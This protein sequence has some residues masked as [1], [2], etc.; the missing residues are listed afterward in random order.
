MTKVVTMIPVR[1]ASTRLPNKPLLDINGKTLVQR[2]YENVKKVVP[3]DVYIAAGDEVIVKEC[4]KFGAKAILTD[5]SLPSGTD[6][7]AA[8]LKEIDPTGTKYDIV[9][10]FQGDSL[11]VDP[12]INNKLIEI[13]EKT[14]CDIATCGMVFKSKEDSENPANVKIVM[15]LRDGEVE[16]RALYFTRAVAPFTRNPEKVKNQDLYHHIGIYVYKASA[17]QRFV[18][19]PVG[20]LENRESLEQLRALEDGMYLRA[21]IV[22]NLKLN[23]DA[24]ADVD[25]EEDLIEARKYIK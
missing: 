1:M 12:E 14:N 7:I 17:L 4:E 21:R 23:Q 2:V 15:G 10:N 16:G 6:R 11:N 20:V 5:P 25:T 24:P 8:A 3:G 22:T 18:S 13:V 19:L 9:V